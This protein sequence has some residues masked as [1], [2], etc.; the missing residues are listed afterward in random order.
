M[1]QLEPL[2]HRLDVPPRARRRWRFWLGVSLLLFVLCLVVL[3]GFFIYWTNRDLREAMAEADRD[4]PGGWQLDD[5]DAHRE[6]IPD[7]ENAALVVLNVKSLLP[8]GWPIKMVATEPA[9]PEDG[10]ATGAPATP[11]DWEKEL[12]ELPPEVQLDE[13]LLQDLRET[14]GRA[15]AA[16]AEAH[17]LVGMTRG[18]FPLVWDENLFLTKLNSPE[19]RT[20]T[21]LLRYDAA[22]A[23]QNGDADRAVALVRGMVGSA[24]SVGDEPFL[25]SSMIRLGCDAQAVSALERVLGQGEPSPQAL[26]AVQELLHKE[27]AESLFLQSVR[28]ER[29][30]THQMLLS[31]RHGGPGLTMMAGAAGGVERQVLEFTGPTLVRRSHAYILRLFNDYVQAAKLPLEEQPAVM[32]DLAQKVRQA[33]T[34]Y[35]F[36][37]ALIMPA[38]TKVSEAHRRGVGNLRCALVAV[39]LERY[40]RDHGGWPDKLDSLVPKYLAAVP[41]DPQDGKVLR[42]KRRPDG[43]VIYWV[44]HD[45]KDNGGNLNRNNFLAQGS[46]QGFQLWDVKQRRQPAREILPPPAEEVIPRTSDNGG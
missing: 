33:H 44:G 17:K 27:A 23:S 16:R 37:T 10:N 5:I 24:R 28:G 32:N 2:E 43:V 46:D 7:D 36:I 30:S 26:E 41:T 8:A 6:Q 20:A 13:D 19:A 25:I 1:S 18:R 12:S 34:Q 39:A 35:D 11:R 45:G 29:A 9:Q 22:L 42:F 38:I 14:L 3:Y 31:W 21:N 4:S 40:R 15:Q